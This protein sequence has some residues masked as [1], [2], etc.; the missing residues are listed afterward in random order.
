MEPTD[1]WV[2]PKIVWKIAIKT[3]SEAN[4]SEHWSKSHKRH[5]QQQ[6]FIRLAFKRETTKIPLPCKV[7]LIRV[8]PRCL[9]ADENLPMAFKWI[10]DEISECLIPEMRK[11]YVTKKGKIQAIK[12]RADSDPR[13]TWKFDQEKSKTIGIRIEFFY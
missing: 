9:D 6:L 10:K 3:V 1:K 13:I 2:L 11:V 8:G 7:R 4:R 12:G 5:K